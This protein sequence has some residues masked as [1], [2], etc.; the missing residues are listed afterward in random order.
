MGQVG[1]V[2]VHH[3]DLAVAEAIIAIEGDQRVAG[4]RKISFSQ[5]RE[6]GTKEA[7]VVETLAL[8]AL[9]LA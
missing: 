6:L 8:T 1:A 9:L 4:R 5:V 3:V 7:E 2:R